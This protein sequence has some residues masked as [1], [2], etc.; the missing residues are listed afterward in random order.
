MEKIPGILGDIVAALPLSQTSQM[1]R[2]ISCSG[3]VNFTGIGIL[4]L[5]LFVFTAGASWFIYK[6]KIFSLKKQE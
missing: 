2:T 3:K 4:L 1:I 5:Y 6:K